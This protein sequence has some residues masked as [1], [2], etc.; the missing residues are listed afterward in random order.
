MV[1]IDIDHFTMINET[2]GRDTG[3]TLLQQVATTIASY[4]RS[5][6]Q[7]ARTEG[8]EYQLL[9][10][11]TSP[12]AAFET[13]EQIRCAIERKPWISKHPEARITV[14][15]GICNR[16]SEKSFEAILA[17][18]DRALDQAKKA[19]RNKTYDAAWREVKF[20]KSAW[21]ALEP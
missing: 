18:A 20:G 12:V 7:F 21:P 8:A 10:L 13:C 4:M 11:D 5:A 3:D 1:V 16:S 15:I 9:L 19:G 17:A 6:D 14:S 2:Y